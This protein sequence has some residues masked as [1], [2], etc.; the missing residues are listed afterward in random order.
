VDDTMTV[1]VSALAGPITVCC[2][3]DCT[4]A[5]LSEVIAK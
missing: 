2:S 1:T 5:G 4:L 3:P